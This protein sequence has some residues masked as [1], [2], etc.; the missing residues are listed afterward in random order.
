M[1][2]YRIDK[3]EA[4]SVVLKCLLINRGVTVD[5]EV[6][7]CFGGQYR[8]HR[9]PETCNS[10]RLSD[11]TNVQL[12][13]ME[14][15]SS[16][17]LGTADDRPALFHRGEQLD[18]VSFERKTGFY[19]QRTSGGRP[20]LGN[21]VLQGCDFVSFPCIWSC[22]YAEAGS[23]C[24]FCFA[25]AEFERLAKAGVRMPDALSAADVA[26]IVRY[27]VEHGDATGIQL[28]GGSTFGGETEHCHIVACLRAIAGMKLGLEGEMLL[29]ITPPKHT[30]YL[31]E[32]FALGADRIACS[33]EVWD[34]ELAKLITPGKV[35]F[36]SRARHLS[37]LEYIAK[38]YGRNKAFS[39]FVI[40]LER[41]ETLKE[42]ATY[43]AQ[44]GIIPS[45]SVWMP[46]GRISG[47][48]QRP[49]IDYF[50]RVK[51]MLDE[52]Y[53]RYMLSPPGGCGLNVCL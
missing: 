12:N 7:E 26:E 30:E 4:D 16:F 39:N 11:G 14:P 17:R 28:A 35:S 34:E 33:L 3:E 42:G 23:P 20:F 13:D 6:F 24:S 43:L 21:V 53:L 15:E 49:S 38:N 37:A 2:K 5:N 9:N 8:L 50:R 29:Y 31:D 51:D 18:F 22:E 27:A 10:F 1:N 25:G 36:S 52:L 47:D 41:F 19:G 44:R 46:G 32:Y 45:A 48:F 40:G